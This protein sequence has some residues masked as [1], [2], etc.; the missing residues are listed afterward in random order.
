MNLIPSSLSSPF[1]S[2]STFPSHAHLFFEQPG[3]LHH[4]SE[5]PD[6]F[7]C[8]FL[9]W[10]LHLGTKLF[11]KRRRF[12]LL[13]KYRVHQHLDSILCRRC[14]ICRSGVLAMILPDGFSD[15]IHIFVNDIRKVIRL[16]D[17]RHLKCAHIN[18]HLIRRIFLHD[19]LARHFQYRIHILNSH[20]RD[21]IYD[22]LD[23][24]HQLAESGVRHHFTE[25]VVID[26]PAAQQLQ[27]FITQMQ[28]R[29]VHI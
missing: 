2:V 15:L 10:D 23:V 8:D 11:Q 19:L 24:C 26:L 16:I 13:I 29:H 22:D 5:R 3:L 9:L 20:I 12:I 27:Y 6:L 14:F 4:A 17:L 25:Q 1:I 18:I 21:A 7:L 28:G